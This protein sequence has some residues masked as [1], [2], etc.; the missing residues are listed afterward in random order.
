MQSGGYAQGL[1]GRFVGWAKDVGVWNAESRM[2]GLLRV[3]STD[4]KKQEKRMYQ[5]WSELDKT[6]F[7]KHMVNGS[8]WNNTGDKEANDR[9]LVDE[10]IVD[11]KF[12][13]M[14]AG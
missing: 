3:N 6:D 14:T 13:G 10:D 9:H 2:L 4:V 5:A 8:N 7:L 1:V 12:E 11:D